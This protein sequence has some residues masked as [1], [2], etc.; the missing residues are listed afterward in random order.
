[1]GSIRVHKLLM[2]YHATPANPNGL[3][4]TKLF[5]GCKV[6]ANFQPILRKFEKGEE[7]TDTQTDNCNHSVPF[8][9]DLTPTPL[10]KNRGPYQKGQKVLLQKPQVHKGQSPFSSPLT[11][12]KV[13]GNW[14]LDGK[15]WN[16][17]KIK[18]Y[19]DPNLQWATI[20]R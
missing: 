2:Q 19:F 13:L 11:V 18:C 9:P 20:E 14:L 6:H 5:L 1:M 3:S 4:P 7:V 12:Q 16:V 17:C 15:V 10:V 8:A